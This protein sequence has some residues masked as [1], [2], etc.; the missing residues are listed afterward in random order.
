MRRIATVGALG[1]VAAVA[2]LAMATSGSGKAAKGAEEIRVLGE[3]TA[4]HFIDNPPVGESAG[5]LV[6]FTERVSLSG[7][8]I[9]EITGRCFL[10]TPPA[11]FQC[12]ALAKLPKGTLTQVANVG[13]GPAKG[14]ITGG[15]GR[16][17]RARGTFRVEP[18]A[19]GR[20]RITY[21]VL[22]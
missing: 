6:V 11:S 1:A 21:R 5:D 10:I 16:F 2:A 9:G 13:E 20:E 15:T 19:E 14:A 17:R 12:S 18:I 4:Q 7:R 22:D 3:I 8:T